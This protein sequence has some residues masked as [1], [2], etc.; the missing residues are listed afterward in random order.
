MKTLLL[1]LAILVMVPGVV[2]S[3]SPQAQKMERQ[4]LETR[5]QGLEIQH[6]Q[7]QEERR[8]SWRQKYQQDMKRLIKRLQAAQPVG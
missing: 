8:Q 4:Q 5:K 3:A 6:W 1:S 7:T 2:Y